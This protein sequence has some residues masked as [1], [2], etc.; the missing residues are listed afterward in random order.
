MLEARDVKFYNYTHLSN[1]KYLIF[2]LS[3][4][5]LHYEC[6]PEYIVSA[7]ARIIQCVNKNSF[8]FSSFFIF[9]L[10]L[11]SFYFLFPFF[12]PI[13]FPFS[14]SPSFCNSFSFLFFLYPFSKIIQCHGYSFCI[15]IHDVMYTLLLLEFSLFLA[16][17]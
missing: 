5:Q 2:N 8:L 16:N 10:F 6:Q 13:S 1:K 12:F 7:A 4:I 14:F 9:L 15:T 11:F 17:Y 3:L